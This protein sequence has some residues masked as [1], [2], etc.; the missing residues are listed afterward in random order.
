[1]PTAGSAENARRH[2]EEWV[3]EDEPMTEAQAA[4]LR[5]LCEESGEAFDPALSKA[6]AMQRI[7]S[8]QKAKGA[9]SPPILL[10]EQTD[11]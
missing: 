2:P 1:M 11:G 3:T 7:E 9:P 6:D 4:V 10:E 5:T 8:L